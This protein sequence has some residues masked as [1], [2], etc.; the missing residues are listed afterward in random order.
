MTGTTSYDNLQSELRAQPRRWLVTGAAGFIGSA[1]VEKLVELGQT[2]TG[3]DNFATGHRRNVEPFASD[4]T[5]IDGDICDEA[6]CARACEGV[7]YVLHQAAIGSVPRSIDEPMVTHRANVDGFVSMALAAR[8]AGAKRFV[9]ASS[10]SVYGDDEGLPKVESRTGRA[11]SPYAVSKAIDELYGAI[12]QDTYGLESVGLRYFNIFGRR[13]D[14][15]G[16]YAAVIPRWID[17]LRTGKSCVIFGDGKNSRDFCYVD[18]AVQANLLAAR[19]AFAATNQVYNVGC[20]DRTDLSEL[21]E[22]IRDLVADRDSDVRDRPPVH[23]PP[24]PGDIAHSLA[25]IDKIR[26]AM[27]YEPTHDVRLGMAETVAW[28]LGSV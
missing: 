9:Y 16:A 8:E 6:T 27:G 13:Q 14:P 28:F 12:I 19:C 21:Y 7:D 1:L 24:R 23:E 26:G 4:I 2:V 3:L 10:S 20:E 5:F 11:L 22:L 15:K 18:N 25:N 17:L